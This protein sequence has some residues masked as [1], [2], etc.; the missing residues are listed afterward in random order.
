MVL[1]PVTQQQTEDGR[2]QERDHHMQGELLGQARARQGQ[3]GLG[4]F[5]P[6]HQHDR[7]DRARLNSNVK[8]LRTLIVKAEQGA[9]QDQMARRRN[10]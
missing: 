8:H 1:D 6:K 9:Q 5:L 7:E 3:H 2:G 10:G 4:Y